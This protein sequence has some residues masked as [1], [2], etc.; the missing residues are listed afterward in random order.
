M[1][2]AELTKQDWENAK[3]SAVK[4]LKQAEMIRVQAEMLLNLANEKIKCLT[5]TTSKEEEKNIK[6]VKD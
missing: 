3:E 2:H 4:E 5:K 6:S 1:S